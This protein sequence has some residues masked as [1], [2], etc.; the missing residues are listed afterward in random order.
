MQ[1][2]MAS[3]LVSHL[4]SLSPDVSCLLPSLFHR[5]RI[6]STC[7]TTAARNLSFIFPYTFNAAQ[8]LPS[9]VRPCRVECSNHF[10]HC[11]CRQCSRLGRDG[12]IWN[13][14]CFLTIDRSDLTSSVTSGAAS[15]GQVITSGAGGAFNTV[16]SGGASVGQVI[17]SGAG[18]AFNTVTSGAVGA[19]STAT[20]GAASVAT[21]VV[22]SGATAAASSV[23]RVADN[24]TSAA[25]SATSRAAAATGVS[26]AYHA[27]L[28]AGAGAAAYLLL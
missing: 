18:G 27:G 6:T 11:Q 7:S 22:A 17:T 14:G 10:R 1:E 9:F 19:F 13:V 5:D 4:N 24:V 3:S 2:G 26:P 8:W 16:T 21:G 12:R 23:T 20:S 15:V 28:A 25:G